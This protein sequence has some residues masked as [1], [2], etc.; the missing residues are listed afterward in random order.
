MTTNL[1]INPSQRVSITRKWII[2]TR[3]Y[4]N[5]IPSPEHVVYGSI[6]ELTPQDEEILDRYEYA[7]DKKPVPVTFLSSKDSHYVKGPIDVMTYIDVKMVEEGQIAEEYIRRMQ[8]AIGGGIKE[9]I[10]EKYF[11]LYIHPFIQQVELGRL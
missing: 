8:R 4:A 11:E 1:S 3:G 6:Y 10:P 2:N 5:I 9:G 7:Y